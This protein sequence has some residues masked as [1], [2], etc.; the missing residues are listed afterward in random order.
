MKKTVISMMVC[1][2]FASI[3][4][5]AHERMSAAERHA[6]Q[7]IEA[8]V[9]E[10]YNRYGRH[11]SYYPLLLDRLKK[12]VRNGEPF[13]K[14]AVAVFSTGMSTEVLYQCALE[15]GAA[16]E[17]PELYT[18]GITW[19]LNTNH[20]VSLLR[21]IKEYQKGEQARQDM[22]A[23]FAQKN[24][25]EPAYTHEEKEHCIEQV[26]AAR[27]DVKKNQHSTYM[28]EFKQLLDAK[29]TANKTVI[30]GCMKEA[31]TADLLQTAALYGHSLRI[32]TMQNDK[33]LYAKGLTLLLKGENAADIISAI[34][35]YSRNMIDRSE[36]LQILEGRKAL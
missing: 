17:D 23:V 30:E 6:N 21:L 27:E 15:I 28:A 34:N 13:E 29:N 9:T 35:R 32:S 24:A 22:L 7:R 33:E 20:I 16:D 36:M 31:K 18:K 19:A 8:A 26:K 5:S 25:S 1:M 14:C 2:V 3:Y 10:A 11:G 12:P 4:L